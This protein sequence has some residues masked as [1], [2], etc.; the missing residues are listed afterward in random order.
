[1]TEIVHRL[2]ALEEAD[3]MAVALYVLGLEFE[4]EDTL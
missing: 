2:D 3:A 1:M 4:T